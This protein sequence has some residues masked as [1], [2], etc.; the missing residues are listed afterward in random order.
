M[1][2]LTNKRKRNDYDIENKRKLI[3]YHRA[4]QHLSHVDLKKCN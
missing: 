3:W 4:N 2:L 1:S